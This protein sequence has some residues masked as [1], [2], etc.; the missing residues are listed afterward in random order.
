MSGKK[1][2]SLTELLGGPDARLADL[3]A[4]AARLDALRRRL[5][6]L[7]PAEAAPHCLG[8]DLEQGVLTLFLDS[9]VWTTALRYRH[10]AIVASTQ[11]ALKLP[12]HTLKLKVLPD[13]KPGV[14]PRPAPRELSPD[15]RRLLDSTAEGVEDADL[16]AALRRL[17]RSPGSRP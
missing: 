16:A 3:A 5:L 13:P 15:T 14:P 1:A 10:Q 11:D 6:P 8:A 7:L 17:A 2:S 9:G 12:C 4:E